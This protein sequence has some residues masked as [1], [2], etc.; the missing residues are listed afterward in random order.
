MFCL[1]TSSKLSYQQFEFSLKVMGSNPGYLLKSFLLYL[2]QNKT[3]KFKVQV[4]FFLELFFHLSCIFYRLKIY[5]L[6]VQ[7]GN[8][9][10]WLEQIEDF[11]IFQNSQ[12]SELYQIE[13]ALYL[14]ILWHGG[15]WRHGRSY[16]SLS[17]TMM[18]SCCCFY[19]ANI[20]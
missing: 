2:H 17:T 14:C 12:W 10:L 16:N 18:F 5:I 4:H 1:I 11:V 6:N 9:Y 19:H 3:F 8:L 20:I 15:I 13:L 7:V